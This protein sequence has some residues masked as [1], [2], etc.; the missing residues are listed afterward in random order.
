MSLHVSCQIQTHG[1][2]LRGWMSILPQCFM[3][4]FWT[5]MVMLSVSEIMSMSMSLS[6]NGDW[7]HVLQRCP[8]TQ[9]AKGSAVCSLRRLHQV[10]LRMRLGGGSDLWRITWPMPHNSP[11][12]HPVSCSDAWA[13]WSC[14]LQRRDQLRMQAHPRPTGNVQCCRTHHDRAMPCGPTWLEDFTV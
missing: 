12:T 1:T 4:P 14:R 6:M 13:H 7:L 10:A 2:S 3:C 8:D 9:Q 5:V 11:V